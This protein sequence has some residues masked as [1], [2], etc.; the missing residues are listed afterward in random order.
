MP[1]LKKYEVYGRF[2]WKL[3]IQ[4]LLIVFTTSQAL[5]VVNQSTTY[6]YSQYTLWNKIFL[7]KNV[8]GSDT[9][10]TN[11]YNIFGISSLTSYIQ[12]TVDSYYD[13][14]SHTIDD[15]LYKYQ[16]DGT[17]KP[18]KLLVEYFDNSDA[19]NKGLEIEYSL[20]KN[21]LGPITDPNLQDY[22]RQAKK[23]EIQFTFIHKLDQYVSLASTCYEWEIVQKY[24][25]STHGAIT[26]QLDPNRKTCGDAN[27]KNY[28]VNIIKNYLWI[29]ICVI[30]LAIASLVTVTRYI[31]KRLDLVMQLMDQS[32]NSRTAWESLGF[33]EKLKFFNFWVI[34][35]VVGN[36]F[37]I[38]GAILSFLDQNTVLTIHEIVVGFGC[39]F[40]WIGIVRFLNHTSHSYTIVNTLTR[41][42]ETIG[43]YIIGVVPIFMGYAMLGLCL[44]WQTG[45]YYTV[46]MSMLANFAVVNGDS[47][48]LFS[49]AGYT[50][51]AFIGQM[52][53]YTF[54]VF[55][56]W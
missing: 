54:V 28:L 17:K 40:A 19:F 13:I 4:I 14:N 29:S 37:Q 21:D 35:M 20:Y 22:L 31:Q 46:P 44:F 24:D 5:L 2:P 49:D 9:T 50:E 47:V 42:G 10:I 16:D 1:P 39:F 52:Y 25:Y 33:T 30:I 45:I 3:V 32:N 7:N 53:Y 55:F 36:L 12:S 41:S 43:L 27:G 23:F 18:A 48:Y 8:Q 26:V 15:Y 34:F 6:S 56:I 51:S 38:F 11:T